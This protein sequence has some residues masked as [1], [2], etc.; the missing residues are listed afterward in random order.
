VS[1]V[2]PYLLEAAGEHERSADVARQGMREAEANG[3]SRALG[4][5]LAMNVAEPLFAL[6][7]WDESLELAER[8][9][10]LSPP[11]LY[12]SGLRMRLT[13]VALARGQVEAAAEALSAARGLGSAPAAVRASHRAD[14]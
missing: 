12:Q 4:T 3:L 9:L 7:R 14:L 6:G 10:E 11:T 5:F 13:F 2:K 1:R 8:A